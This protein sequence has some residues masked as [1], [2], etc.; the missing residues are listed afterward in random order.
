MLAQAFGEY[1][2]LAPLIAAIESTAFSVSA[3][4]RNA[5]P[6]VWIPVAISTLVVIWLWRSK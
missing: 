5:G 1:A 4:V 6:E 2:T 3:W